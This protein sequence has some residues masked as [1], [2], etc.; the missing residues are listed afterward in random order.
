[1]RRAPNIPFDPAIALQYAIKSQAVYTDKPTSYNKATDTA[2][3]ITE[4]ETSIDIGF[5]GTRDF[6]DVWKDLKAYRVPRLVGGIACMVHAGFDCAW[7]SV[8]A[9]VLDCLAGMPKDKP[10]RG[11]GHSK[12]GALITRSIANIL[13][14]SDR[15]L[16]FVYTY[17]EPRGGDSDYALAND[18]LFGP[19]HFRVEDGD[20]AIC[21]L[22][23]W[24]A[25]NRH[26]GHCVLLSAASATYTIDKG[27]WFKAA[28]D[29]VEIWQARWKGNILVLGED[30][31]IGKYVDR[32]RILCNSK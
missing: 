18:V 19:R 12:G 7:E 26:C 15:K 11:Y 28:S 5:P 1:M 25:G 27:F 14:A 3:L 9:D 16:D 8:Q 20:D 31:H 13:Q 4:N 24:L 6:A 23:G 22:P 10:L 30:H 29:V 32:L 21:R 17:G 2:V